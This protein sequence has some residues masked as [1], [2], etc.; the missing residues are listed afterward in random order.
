MQPNCGNWCPATALGMIFWVRFD[1]WRLL[2]ETVPFSCSLLE[3]VLLLNNKLVHS[4]KVIYSQVGWPSPWTWTWLLSQTSLPSNNLL[5]REEMIHCY[6]Y[7]LGW[8]LKTE[9]MCLET[10]FFNLWLRAW[11]WSQN[12]ENMPSDCITVSQD[13]FLPRLKYMI[14]SENCSWGEIS[15]CVWV[16]QVTGSQRFVLAA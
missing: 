10:S 13:Q 4:Q 5:N 1:L 9:K 2:W 14:P 16:F 7:E 12:G 11:G 8:Y 6:N 3:V 15:G